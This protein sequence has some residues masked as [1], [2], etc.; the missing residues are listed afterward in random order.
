MEMMDITNVCI[1]GTCP[2]VN[3]LARFP[4]NQN[5]P[6]TET[7]AEKAVVEAKLPKKRGRPR[8][9]TSTTK[10][11]R[12]AK[13]PRQEKAGE[14]AELTQTLLLNVGNQAGG[15]KGGGAFALIRIA[16]FALSCTSF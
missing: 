15:S 8:S 2:S 3:F 5:F 11:G 16:R 14:G 1:N 12:P 9:S 6:N 4:S 10:R 13:K 7:M